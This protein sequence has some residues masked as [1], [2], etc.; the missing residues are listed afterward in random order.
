[1]SESSRIIGR[2]D[3]WL[4]TF[5][6]QYGGNSDDKQSFRH[7]IFVSLASCDIGLQLLL[8]SCLAGKVRNPISQRGP[9]SGR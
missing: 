1:M 4:V 7:P 8:G 6:P 3:K 5:E 2:V 9:G